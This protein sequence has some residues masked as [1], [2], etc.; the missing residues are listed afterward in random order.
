MGI[1]T[2][3]LC[4]DEYC[5]L[6][7]CHIPSLQSQVGQL[8][9][10]V[11]FKNEIV[12]VKIATIWNRSKLHERGDA[13][14][15]GIEYQQDIF[16]G[17]DL[18]IMFIERNVDVVSYFKELLVNTYLMG[19][20]I[21][22]NEKKRLAD[23]FESDIFGDAGLRHL[24]C[25]SQGV[26]RSFVILVKE[27]INKFINNKRGTK[28]LGVIYELIRHQYLEDVRNKIPYYTV[29]K[30]INVFV[31]EKL[32][33]YFLISR[34]DYD[35]CK[36]MIKYLAS[37]GVFMQMPGHLTDRSIRDDYK[38]FMINYGNYLDALESASH[39]QGRKTLEEDAAL[40]ENGRLIPEYDDDL[41]KSPDVYTVRLS[42]HAEDEFYCLTC[43]K[44]YLDAT[45]SGPLI[46]P[47]CG[48]TIQ[49]FEEFIDE[50][51]L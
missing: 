42:I 30:D 17:P 2:A 20:E 5:E 45:R 25:G 12:S 16:A 32:C 37:R 9:K 46:C 11:F 38:L 28:Q 33:R 48:R 18:D 24:I 51:S 49:R 1:S 35:R 6:D 8:I 23:Y 36:E 43:H 13:R 40:K 39:K 41:L 15:W 4:I 31:G 21:S 3:F 26:S 44:I 34:A 22:D 27:Y 7:K 14:V 19:E 47:V 29:Y 10:Q 50:M